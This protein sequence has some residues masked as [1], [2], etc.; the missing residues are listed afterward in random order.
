MN[1][2]LAAMAFAC[3]TLCS[4]TYVAARA[5]P[6]DNAAKASVLKL[7]T[8]RPE[9]ARREE[10][11]DGVVEAVN[12]A[13]MSAQ[14][15]GRVLEAPFDVNDYVPAGSLIIKLSDVEQKAAVKQAQANF[16]AANNSF[17]RIARLYKTRTVSKAAYDSAKAKRDS[18]E[19]ALKTAQQ[20][21]DYTTIKAPYSGIVTKRYVQVGEEVRPGEK[22]IAGIS[23]DALRVSVQIPQS[24]AA[25]VR[26]YSAAD[27]LLDGTGAKRLAAKQ[28]IVFPYAD[29]QTHT[30]NVRLILPEAETGLYPGMTVKCAFEVGESS[31]LLIP[32]SALVQRSEMSAVYVVSGDDIALRQLRL[33]HRFGDRIEVLSGLGAGEKIAADPIAAA[34]LVAEQRAE[35]SKS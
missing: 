3:F 30:F 18:A 34:A 32:V 33:G 29:P 11:W 19:A 9:T 35:A 4:L 28:V 1:R 6:A 17:G 14:T 25:A 2:F 16:D 7:I 21:L 31:R 15:S 23:L 5:A 12:E 24:A 8:V 20:Q 13:T 26:K 10:V 22:L 27:I